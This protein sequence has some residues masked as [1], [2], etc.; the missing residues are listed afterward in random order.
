MVTY[1]TTDPARWGTGKGANLTAG[2][3]DGNFWE[4][5]ERIAGV[6]GSAPQPNNIANVTVTGS[7][8]TIHMQDGTTHGPFTLPTAMIHYRGDWVAGAA[9]SELDLVAEPT[10]G[11]FL[12]LRD[13]TAAAAFDA[14]ATDASGSPLYRYLFPISGGAGALSELSDVSVG[15]PADGM[16]LTWYG[17]TWYPD[18]IPA[19]HINDLNGIYNPEG[20]T[21]GQ[22]LAFNVT[23]TGWWEPMD[24]PAAGGAATFLDLTDTPAAFGA[25]GTV[26]AVNA[27]GTALEFVSPTSSGGIPDAPTDGLTYGRLNGGWSALD[28]VPNWADI[29]DRPAT[30]PPAVHT[31][32]TS[33][34]TNFAEALQDGVAG[35][36][37][38]GTNVTLTYDD[39]AGTVTIASSGTDGTGAGGATTFLGL[40][41]TPAAYGTAGQLAAVNGTA[42]GLVFVDPPAGTGG[43][44]DSYVLVPSGDV[45]PPGPYS[46]SAFAMKGNIFVV[47]EPIRIF[48][49]APALEGAVG[50]TYKLVVYVVDAAN[51]VQTILFDGPSVPV[52]TTGTR[53]FKIEDGLALAAGARVAIAIVRSDSL[54]TTPASPAFPSSLPQE[55]WRGLDHITGVRHES[56]GAAPGETIATVDGSHVPMLIHVMDRATIGVPEAPQDGTPYARQDGAWVAG[57]SGGAYRGA[58]AQ[59]DFTPGTLNTFL[60]V[61]LAASGVDT[62]GVGFDDANDRFVIPAG[63]SLVRLRIGMVQNAT[64]DERNQWKIAKNG[65]RLDPGQGSFSYVCDPVG[66]NNSG[67][68]G[69][70][71]PLAV[72]AGDVLELHA[73]SAIAVTFI[74]W[75]ELE[76]LA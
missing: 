16:V 70:T 14:V 66:F 42:D 26:P 27:A 15:T 12:V 4:L 28:L 60:K 67:R 46:T 71:G 75:L 51:V 48:G 53:F 29:P 10:L 54:A 6:E 7:Q 47:T 34:I 1:R 21:T 49:V 11:I 36:L 39:A 68:E 38:A 31:H 62:G 37:V 2:E 30:F 8:M 72:V 32:A 3:I 65:I 40:T 55:S 24:L 50:H 56:M 63:I 76:V 9:Y 41:D 61:P 13:H 43:A 64:T 58:R 20:A 73:Y 5:A 45:P 59:V 22:V 57:A 19:Q 18:T 69:V 17:G 23:G 52:E 74:G 25:P 33:D 35:I 44:G